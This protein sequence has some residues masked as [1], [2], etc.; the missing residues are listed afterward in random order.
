VGETFPL[1]VT[2]G[3]LPSDEELHYVLVMQDISKRK[4]AEEALHRE[5]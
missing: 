3:D 4:E 5:K 2:V 1:S